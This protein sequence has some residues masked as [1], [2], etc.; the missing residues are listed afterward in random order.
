MWQ[1]FRNESMSLKFVIWEREDVGKIKYHINELVSIICYGWNFVVATAHK[2]TISIEE[3]P[4]GKH[5][6]LLNCVIY[7]KILTGFVPHGREKGKKEENKKNWCGFHLLMD[8]FCETQSFPLCCSFFLSFEW[9][10][11][12]YRS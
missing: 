6:S 5:I 11:W 8:Y 10:Q 9:V 12:E 1:A 3:V 2:K 7:W 4:V